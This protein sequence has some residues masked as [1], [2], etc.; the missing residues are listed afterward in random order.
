MWVGIEEKIIYRVNIEG[1]N[2]I[3]TGKCQS[4]YFSGV[5][6]CSDALC[7][8]SSWGTGGGGSGNSHYGAFAYD[9]LSPV[10]VNSCTKL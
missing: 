7:A 9:P 4:G 2:F 1:Y 8:N 5:L 3:G 10:A 6:G